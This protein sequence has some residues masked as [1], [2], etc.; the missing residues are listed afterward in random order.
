MNW[1][2]VLERDDIIGGNL[3]T[4]EGNYLFCGP[5]DGVKIQNGRVRIESLW[6]A[7][8]TISGFDGWVYWK[9][10]AAIAINTKIIP[11]NLG[12]GDI[13][14]KMPRKNYGVI[15]R[16]GSGRLLNPVMVNGI[17]LS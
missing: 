16:K 15:N 4:H 2:E 7:R 17:K 12:D 11:V 14:F 5:I 6:V 9:S 1:G 3:L 10:L 13:G 8:G